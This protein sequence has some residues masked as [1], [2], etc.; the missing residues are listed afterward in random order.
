MVYG[1]E[2][3]S[4]TA[5]NIEIQIRNILAFNPKAK[6]YQESGSGRKKFDKLHRIVKPT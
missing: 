3:V 4:T 5:Q 6:L 2:Q 1:Y